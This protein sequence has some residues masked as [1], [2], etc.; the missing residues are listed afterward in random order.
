MSGDLVKYSEEFNLKTDIDLSGLT[1]EQI[2]VLR[3]KLVVSNISVAS[4]SAS[5]QLR[6]DAAM[7]D[8]DN[9]IA[10]AI[11]LEQT[12]SEYNVNTEADS[13]SAK[14]TI[15][16]S[17]KGDVKYGNCLAAIAI[18]LAIA[19]FIA[20]IAFGSKSKSRSSYRSDRSYQKS[21]SSPYRSNPHQSS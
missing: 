2:S 11:K 21:G 16:M 13:G 1:E 17:S 7:M 5:R 10:N 20:Y 3:Q 9:A 14:T 19:G 12:S 18:I 4:D 15:S 8:V 6:L